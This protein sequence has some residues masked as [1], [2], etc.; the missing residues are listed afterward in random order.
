MFNN[1]YKNGSYLFLKKRH[2]SSGVIP[3]RD[4][5]VRVISYLAHLT[6]IAPYHY[7]E[8]VIG[9]VPGMALLRTEA[10]ESHVYWEHRIS[11]YLT[12]AHNP[13]GAL[14]RRV[15]YI[16]EQRSEVTGFVA[17]HL[18]QR[19]GFQGEL[20]WINVGQPFRGT[21]MASKLLEELAGWFQKVNA[22]RV[23]VNVVP[24]NYAAQAFYRK[25]G[26]VD[27]QPNWLCWENISSIIEKGNCGGSD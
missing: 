27:F 20:Q 2:T 11:A 7:K 24:E 12:G 13:Q 4:S 19:F 3:A 22:M 21:G 26:A 14:P 1:T 17:G 25:H 18:T 6:E 5:P 16:A 15:L 10:G 8:A 9:D 23:C